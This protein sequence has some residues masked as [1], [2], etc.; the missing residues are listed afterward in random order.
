[1][2]VVAVVVLLHSISVVKKRRTSVCLCVCVFSW[3]SAVYF[4]PFAGVGLICG[5]VVLLGYNGQEYI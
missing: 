4:K 1:M 3:S 2:V 5:G